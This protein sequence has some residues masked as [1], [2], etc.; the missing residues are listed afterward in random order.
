MHVFMHFYFGT[1]IH[2]H[3][4]IYNSLSENEIINRLKTIPS[5]KDVQAATEKNDSNGGLNKPGKYVSAIYF[6]LENVDQSYFD[7]NLD[8]VGKGTDCGGQIKVY[9]KS[10]LCKVCQGSKIFAKLFSKS[11]FFHN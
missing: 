8:I 3:I 6:E 2:F 1:F 9:A 5:V 10:K 11:G 7:A 4:N